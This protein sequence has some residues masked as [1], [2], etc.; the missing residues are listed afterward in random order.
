MQFLSYQLYRNYPWGICLLEVSQTIYVNGWTFPSCT[1]LCHG[2][3]YI[4][5]TDEVWILLNVWLNSLS[6]EIVLYIKDNLCGLQFH[7]INFL[8]LIYKKVLSMHSF[9]RIYWLSILSQSKTVPL[10]RVSGNLL[11]YWLP[12]CTWPSEKLSVP[13]VRVTV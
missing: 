4:F 10:D 9:K 7:L 5:F 1:W 13:H 3:L 8:L 12:A 2:M 6:V 11:Y